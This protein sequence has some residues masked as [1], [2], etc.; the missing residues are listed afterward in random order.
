MVGTEREGG[1]GARAQEF[2][3]SPGYTE[4]EDKSGTPAAEEELAVGL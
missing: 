1:A 4:R 3:S 2:T